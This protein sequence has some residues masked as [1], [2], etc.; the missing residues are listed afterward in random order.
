MKGHPSPKLIWSPQKDRSS[1]GVF[2]GF[3]AIL[4]EE[5]RSSAQGLCRIRYLTLWDESCGY[6]WCSVFLFWVAL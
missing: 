3:H 2:W 1:S 4:E 5:I 6:V